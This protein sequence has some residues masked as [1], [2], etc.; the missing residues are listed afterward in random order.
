[1]LKK[2][3]LLL[4]LV[5]A[6]WFSGCSGEEPTTPTP[7]TSGNDVPADGPESALEEGGADAALPPEQQVEE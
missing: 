2:M 6:C 5:I 3:N 1:M 4:T 7:A